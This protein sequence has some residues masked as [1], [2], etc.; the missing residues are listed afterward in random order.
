MSIKIR[1]ERE[2]VDSKD[3]DR[4]MAFLS[5]LN[6]DNSTRISSAT[7]IC[8]ELTDFPNEEDYSFERGYGVLSDTLLENLPFM[9]PDAYV[10]EFPELTKDVKR[11]EILKHHEE[12]NYDLRELALFIYKNNNPDR[13]TTRAWE[14]IT[15]ELEEK[16]QRLNKEVSSLEADFN[17]I[18]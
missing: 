15:K 18:K 10:Q 7:Y 13:P 6:I 9:F 3:F 5:G 2:T 8:S 1:E 11:G 4:Y 17:R 16:S 14:R 12:Q